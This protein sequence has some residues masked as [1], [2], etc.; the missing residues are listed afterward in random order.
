[1]IRDTP[2]DVKADK[3]ANAANRAPAQHAAA[4]P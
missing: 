3:T 2:A 1:M 4:A